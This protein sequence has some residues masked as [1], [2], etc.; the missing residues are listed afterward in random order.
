MTPRLEPV[1]KDQWGD[2]EVA[3]IRAG[4]PAAAADRFLS[5]APD[6]PALTNG[7][8][9]MLHHPQ[10][11]AA[12]L[13]YNGQL[14]W[15][16]VLDPR[17]RELAVLRVAWHARAPYEWVQHVK[18]SQRYGVTDQEVEAIVADRTDGWSPL[19]ADVLLA[20]EQLLTAYR[21]DDATWQRLSAAL[22]TKALVELVFVVGTYA[23]LA[24]LFNSLGVE[25]DADLDPTAQPMPVA[26][27][28]P[29]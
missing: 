1:P 18:L 25:L 22:D 11:A 15:D 12:F 29:A 4:M 27:G 16:P 8:A 17:L 26:E 28:W 5:D 6:A 3:A 21:I 13:Q 24:M 14:L 2:A 23:G 10:L 7:I 9:A 20:T 19:E